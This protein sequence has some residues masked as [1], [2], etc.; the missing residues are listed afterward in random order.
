[1][2]VNI[3]LVQKWRLRCRSGVFDR[4]KGIPPFLLLDGHGSRFELKFLQYI[5]SEER[6][7]TYASACHTA[8]AIGKSAIHLSRTAAL[9][10]L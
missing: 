4:S 6:S 5:N 9:R 3:V 10:W 8:Q 2:L 7:G 1:M